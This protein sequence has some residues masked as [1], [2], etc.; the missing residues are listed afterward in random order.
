MQTDGSAVVEASG[1]T[2]SYGSVAALHG[3]DI[4]VPQ[5]KITGLVGP[6]GAGKST[7]MRIILTLLRQDLGKLSVFGLEP[8]RYKTE[9][10][11]RTGY[12]PE[13]FSLYSDLTVEEN[14]QFSFRIHRMDT[15]VYR[16]RLDRQYAFNR[17][18]PFAGA[19]AGTLSGGMKQK[20][21]LSCAMMHDPDLLV[22][23]EPTTG[24]DPL[25]RREFWQ[26][27]HELRDSGLTI[28]VS[29]PY[30]DEAL[31]C[32]AVYFMFRG[33]VVN[34]GSPADL[35][36][37]FR[38]T[39]YEIVPAPGDPEKIIQKLRTVLPS[40]AVYLSGRN[41][42][43]GVYA[44]VNDCPYTACAD[45]SSVKRVTPDLEDL[46]MMRI[47]QMSAQKENSI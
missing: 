33:S 43:A 36:S 29:T 37:S 6:D 30:M 42:H 5:G 19:R 46:F 41:I 25:S 35:V 38:G 40:A 8:D 24:V 32:D 2:K 22:L 34:S 16:E 28:L 45:V 18:R 47:L 7:L 31:Q 23:D 20:L 1:L 17:L 44:D 10:R 13:T 12:M 9:I 27:L 26:M 39:V 3:I 14:M 11:S 4:N 21:A 15:A